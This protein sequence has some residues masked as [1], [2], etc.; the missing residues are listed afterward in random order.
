MAEQVDRS[1]YSDHACH[2]PT[3]HDTLT[4]LI[5][6]GLPGVA[7]GWAP[8]LAGA[9][10]AAGY[11]GPCDDLNCCHP[12]HVARTTARLFGPACECSSCVASDD[13]H[14]WVGVMDG[15]TYDVAGRLVSIDGRRYVCGDDGCTATKPFAD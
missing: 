13:G 8:P 1:G 14:N 6:D 10:L 15:V 11:V 4:A 2:P 12:E 9:I 5:A 7:K 3:D